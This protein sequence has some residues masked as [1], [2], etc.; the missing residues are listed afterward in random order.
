MVRLRSKKM[1]LLLPRTETA[2]TDCRQHLSQHPDIDPAVSAY[3]A[4][5]VNGLMCAEIEQVVSGL[6][7]ARL[8]KG[9]SDAATFNFLTSWQRGWVRSAKIGEIRDTIGLLGGNY[10]DT[11]NNLI[12]QNVGDEGSGKLGRA[13]SD[14]NQNAHENPPDITFRELEDVIPFAKKVVEAVRL[15]L[16]SQI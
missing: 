7:R 2:I 14:R 9:C 6:I 11:F 10:K 12:N 13:V 3:L 16:E 5:Y 1:E 15:T 4:R 8:E